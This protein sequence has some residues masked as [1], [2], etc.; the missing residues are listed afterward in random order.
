MNEDQKNLFEAIKKNDIDTVKYLLDKIKNINEVDDQYGETPLHMAAAYNHVKITKLLLTHENIDINATSRYNSTP[1][2]IACDSA[3]SDIIE[4]L[5]EDPAI[6][7]NLPR[8]DGETPLHR[9]CR[10]GC[11]E[12]VA[13]LLQH[14]QI[15]VNPRCCDEWTPL[16]KA[17]Y[18]ENYIEITKL[19]LAH[20]N[21]E[22]NQ[23]N[24][25]GYTVLYNACSSNHTSF[26]QLLLEHPNINVDMKNT[27]KGAEHYTPLYLAISKKNV[28]LVQR[29]CNEHADPQHKIPLSVNG[30]KTMIT[31]LQYASNLAEDHPSEAT[32]TIYNTLRIKAFGNAK[33]ARSCQDDWA[34]K[35]NPS[36]NDNPDQNTSNTFSPS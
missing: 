22:V 16:M 26:I 15:N 29:L 34:R 27:R 31:L 1:L 11:T 35:P 28:D 10:N 19:L 3:H 32:Q 21:I 7:V 17:L 5:L 6:D 25:L 20:P 36:E 9:A 33:S 13:L 14:P 4:L 8:N 24:R 18:R 2:W 12:D 30:N 23:T